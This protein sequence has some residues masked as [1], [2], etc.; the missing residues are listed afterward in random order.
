MKLIKWKIWERIKRTN[1]LWITNEW[2]VVLEKGK[3]RNIFNPK[4]VY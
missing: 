2:I 3:Y 4:W 1:Q